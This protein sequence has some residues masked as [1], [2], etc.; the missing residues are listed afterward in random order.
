MQQADKNTLLQSIFLR[1]ERRHSCRLWGG[2]MQQ[3][4]K[5]VRAPADEDHFF[6]IN[7]RL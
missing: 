3:A 6:A 5:N 2:R 1:E 7:K 4:D